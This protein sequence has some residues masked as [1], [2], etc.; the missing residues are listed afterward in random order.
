MLRR[1]WSSQSI[2]LSRAI[3][4]VGGFALSSIAGFVFWW[5][6]ARNFPAGAVGIALALVSTMS[7]LSE[8]GQFGLNTL[9]FG[10]LS[11]WP[12]K[13]ASVVGIS[14]ALAAIATA[15]LG[16]AF[17][18]IAPHISGELAPLSESPLMIIT[19]AVGAGLTAF[20]FVID[21]AMI[22]LGKGKIQF[23]RNLIFVFVRLGLI[24]LASY[25][26]VPKTGFLIISIWTVGL[27]VS[28]LAALIILWAGKKQ[29]PK[30]RFENELLREIPKLGLKHH[31][32][33]LSLSIAPYLLP[34]IVVA[35]LS[36][37]IN[38]AYGTAVLI[39]NMIY[40]ATNALAVSTF[41]VSAGDR[42]EL[43]NR[44][45]FSIKMSLLIGAASG[46]VLLI[47]ADW[48]IWIFNA[49]Y[50]ELGGATALRIMVL[51]IFPLLVKEHFLALRR[52]EGK[53]V[54]TT[55]VT[56]IGAAVELIFAAVGA[57]LGGLSGLCVGWVIAVTL[58]MI[59]TAPPLLQLIKSSA[60]TPTKTE[61]RLS[62][63]NIKT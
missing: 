8:I 44:M 51:A 58:Q 23:S 47:L 4:L 21:S 45:R 27:I 53:T 32:L 15:I 36:A 16:L 33:N 63:A 41:S 29:I 7:L 2:L 20:G 25:S 46:I 62:R 5:L 37:E 11:R 57:R 35:L 40:F 60:Q 48:I 31:V 9:V 18:F 49:R 3:S 13:T 43:P 56:L 6:A 42:S 28:L 34:V 39:T 52:V 14:L 17:T 38:A 26:V 1:I 19:F 55:T 30:I 50:L 54:R 12:G 10:E 61:E 24:A 22:A 59:Y